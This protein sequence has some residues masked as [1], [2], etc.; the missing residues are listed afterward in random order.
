MLQAVLLAIVYNVFCDALV[1]GVGGTQGALAGVMTR[2]DAVILPAALVLL[3]AGT[4]AAAYALGMA[5]KLKAQ[6]IPVLMFA[7]AHKVSSLTLA[8]LV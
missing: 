3:Q 6:D 2:Q 1:P 8:L 7:G 5:L 4:L